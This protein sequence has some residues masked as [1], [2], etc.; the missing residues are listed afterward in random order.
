MVAGGELGHHAAVF[1]MQL[2]LAVE[3]VGEQTPRAVV[4]SDAGLI[5]GRFDTQNP[6]D[7]SPQL[8]GHHNPGVRALAS[9]RVGGAAFEGSLR[10]PRF[11]SG[12]RQSGFASGAR[13]R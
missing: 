4:N 12:K 13:S 8:G 2:D 9:L 10:R 3:G 1:G 6:H 7:R 5:A 11:V